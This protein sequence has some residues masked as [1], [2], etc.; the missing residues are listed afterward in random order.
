MK[1]L[2]I[3]LLASLACMCAL[4]Q[5]YKESV[6][7]KNGSVI[8]GVVLEQVPNV[9][10][11]V[12]TSDGS[13]FVFEMDQVEKIT[14]EP[15]ST[16]DIP[17]MMDGTLEW[18]N[19]SKIKVNNESSSLVLSTSDPRLRGCFSKNLYDE[20]SQSTK[21]AKAGMIMTICGASTA[22]IGAGLYIGGLFA[23]GNLYSNSTKA[24]LE[25]SGFSLWGV[26]AAVLAAGIPLWCIGV[27]HQK[28]IID[29]VNYSNGKL[30]S[31]EFSPS[32]QPMAN[33]L[34]TGRNEFAVGATVAFKF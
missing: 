26:S 18:V 4:A 31:F 27:N 14:K 7:L 13:I 5:S 9:S 22:V 24:S 20:F 19:H 34:I 33:S 11:K 23:A 8:K 3:T 2:I 29:D 17:V 30:Y 15:V 25:Y 1:K 21:F 10:L 28:K 6:Y 32:V 16:E 12:Q